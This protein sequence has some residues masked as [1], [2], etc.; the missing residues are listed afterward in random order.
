MVG[1]PNR[2]EILALLFEPRFVALGK[3]AARAFA[4]LYE[5]YISQASASSRFQMTF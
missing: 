5:I 3:A 1:R 4:G 2:A